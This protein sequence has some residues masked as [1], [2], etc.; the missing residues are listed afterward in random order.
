M[1]GAPPPTVATRSGVPAPFDAVLAPLRTA[2]DACGARGPF[3][4]VAWGLPEPDDG[5]WLDLDAFATDEGAAPA[6]RRYPPE[7]DVAK[8]TPFWVFQNVTGTALLAA[9]YLYAAQRRVPS[10]RGTR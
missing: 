1:R 10:L 5:Q 4:S 6:I 3:A 2:L 7:S 8:L 9:G